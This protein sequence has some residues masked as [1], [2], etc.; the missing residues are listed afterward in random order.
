M[1]WKRKLRVVVRWASGQFGLAESNS[2]PDG[3]TLSALP[4]P[5][6]TAGRWTPEELFLGALAGS[7]TTTF[8][9]LAG[10][11]CLAYADLEIDIQSV[12]ERA[13]AGDVPCFRTL[14]VRPTVTVTRQEDREQALD[15]LERV[16]TS[17]PISRALASA[18]RFEPQ[19]E[20]STFIH[21]L[22]SRRR[23]ARRGGAHLLSAASR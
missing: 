4:G 15:L 11:T 19:V 5:G 23:E 6:S 3:V 9:E 1:Q 12:I 21:G 8:H 18:P 16:R 22:T 13:K 14:V 2:A 10:N 17:C 20:V 7:V